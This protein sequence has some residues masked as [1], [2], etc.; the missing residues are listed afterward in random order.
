[1][2]RVVELSQQAPFRDEVQDRYDPAKVHIRMH[3]YA[4]DV[5]LLKLKLSP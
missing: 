5:G 3:N 2:G 4:K 1:M